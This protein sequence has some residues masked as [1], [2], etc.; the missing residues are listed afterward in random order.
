[1]ML[2]QIISIVREAGDIVLGA[3]NISAQT[4]EKGGLIV[5]VLHVYRNRSRAS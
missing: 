3:H 1:M 5:C 4:Q 2:E